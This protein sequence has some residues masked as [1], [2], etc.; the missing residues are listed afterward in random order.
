MANLVND[1]KLTPSPVGIVSGLAFGVPESST[2]FSLFAASVTG[3]VTFLGMQ[4]TPSG[5]PT[6][7]QLWPRGD[8]LA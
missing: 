2:A 7:G 1:I 8:T 5:R 3:T 4:N 6:S